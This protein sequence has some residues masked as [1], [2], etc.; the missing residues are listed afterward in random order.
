MEGEVGLRVLKKI[1]S[2]SASPGE[3]LYADPEVAR[4]KRAFRADRCKLSSRK[5]V[6]K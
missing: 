2:T 5:W 6:E 3:N 1:N 4:E